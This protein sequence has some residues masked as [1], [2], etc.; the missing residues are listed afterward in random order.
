MKPEDKAELARR[1]A[2]DQFAKLGPREDTRKDRDKAQDQAAAK[3]ARL[4]ALRLAKEAEE[5]AEA[6][7]AP[8]DT[9]LSKRK[10]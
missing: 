9:K 6:A 1:R 8:A 7:K 2:Q 3:I 10:S 4:R 5:Q